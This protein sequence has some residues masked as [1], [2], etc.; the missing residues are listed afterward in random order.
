MSKNLYPDDELASL[1]KENSTADQ[2]V[3]FE[4]ALHKTQSILAPDATRRHIIEATG[5][6]RRPSVPTSGSLRFRLDRRAIYVLVPAL[7]ILLLMISFA[8]ER[9]THGRVTTP[10]EHLVIDD[11]GLEADIEDENQ[12]IAAL[13]RNEDDIFSPELQDLEEEL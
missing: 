6:V 8:I 12:V 1:W 3:A 13:L 7:S 10:L 4:R 5:S 2:Q 9:K 11:D